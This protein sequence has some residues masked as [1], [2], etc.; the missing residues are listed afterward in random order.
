[1]HDIDDKSILEVGGTN[2]AQCVSVIGF[3]IGNCD[4]KEKSVKK[5]GGI[6]VRQIEI[7]QRSA[8]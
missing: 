3:E 1:M 7:E 6:R 4:A 8:K 2:V 5:F